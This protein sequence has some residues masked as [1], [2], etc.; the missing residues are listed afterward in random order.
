MNTRSV[1]GWALP[2]T[3]HAVFEYGAQRHLVLN[4][5]RMMRF[6]GAHAPEVVLGPGPRPMG[7]LGDVVLTSDG[8]TAR[9]GDLSP[10]VENVDGTGVVRAIAVE[11]ALVVLDERG[12]VQRWTPEVQQDVV[13]GVQS[14]HD[15]NEA[16][17]L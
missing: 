17:V 1:E 7:L 9:L 3:A 6:D 13:A 5:G 8:S 15:A 14:L 4:D 12:T 2:A 10:R 11:G 16:S